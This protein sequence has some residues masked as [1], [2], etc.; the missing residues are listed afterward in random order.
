MKLPAELAAEKAAQIEGAKVVLK[1]LIF[2]VAF[3]VF[4]LCFW[5]YDLG[6]VL[7]IGAAILVVPIFLLGVAL[8]VGYLLGKRAARRFKARGPFDDAAKSQFVEVIADVLKFQKWVAGDASTED[9]NGQPKR[10]ALGYVYGFVDA[11]LRAR[12]QDMSN[13]LVGV[14]VTF[15]VLRKLW[16]DRATD[17]TT[18]L[19]E[20]IHSDNLM[21]IGIMHGG[22]QYLDYRKPE[23]SGGPMG[24]ARFMIEGDN[25]RGE[26]IRETPRGGPNQRLATNARQQNAAWPNFP[27]LSRNPNP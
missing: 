9:E 16:P 26:H 24:L 1:P 10:K 23:A 6:L 12:G 11:A 7:S 3:I 5:G 18:F 14:P 17:Y 4:A 15:Q 20:N 8:P 19:R 27:P 22:Q 2:I 13:P 25:G 21:M